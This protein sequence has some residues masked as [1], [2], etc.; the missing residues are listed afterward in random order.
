MIFEYSLSEKWLEL[1]KQI[2]LAVTRAAVF[3]D[4]TQGGVRAAVGPGEHDFCAGK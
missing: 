3:Q 2:A 1:L 4:L